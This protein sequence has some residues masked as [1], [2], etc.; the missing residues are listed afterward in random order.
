M[1]YIRVTKPGN[2]KQTK[3]QPKGRVCSCGAR[4]SVYN[5]NTDCNSC[6]HK[7]FSTEYGATT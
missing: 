5:S 1:D 7:K 4:L 3:S 6:T 2:Y